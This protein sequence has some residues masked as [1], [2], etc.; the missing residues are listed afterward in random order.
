MEASAKLQ[1]WVASELR[2]RCI[3]RLLNGHG[4]KS[5]EQAGQEMVYW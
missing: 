1:L 4:V 2:Q 3:S 5:A